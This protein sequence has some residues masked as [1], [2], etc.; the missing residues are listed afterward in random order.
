LYCPL[1]VQQLMFPVKMSVAW[2]IGQDER[3]Q[4]IKSS[5]TAAGSWAWG[6]EHPPV[7]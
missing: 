6:S 7:H 2:S 1:S 5:S 4:A 3:V